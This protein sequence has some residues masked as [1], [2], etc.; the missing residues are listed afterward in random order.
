M[1]IDEIG[2]NAGKIWNAI[3]NGEKKSL[4]VIKK[5][6]KLTEKEIYAAIGWLGREGK[7]ADLEESGKSVYVKVA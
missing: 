7:L 6:T 5:E 3:S 4:A 2:E 1:K